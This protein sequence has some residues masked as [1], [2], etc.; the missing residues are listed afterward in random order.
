MGMHLHN[1]RVWQGPRAT[2]A[3]HSRGLAVRFAA[4]TAAIALNAGASLRAD[5]VQPGVD[6]WST[7]RGSSSH[8]FDTKCE[9]DP[10]PVCWSGTPCEGD[11]PVCPSGTP[12]PAGFFG[13]GSDP[14]DDRIDLQGKEFQYFGTG[15]S[16]APA[17]TIMWRKD[18]A[19]LPQ[20]SATAQDEVRI[21]IIALS[22]TS[23]TPITVTYNGG[24]NPELW[25]V[26]VCLSDW[27]QDEG[28]M[29]IKHECSD[30][31]TF[32]SSLLVTP[33]FTFTRQSD[34][35]EKILDIG[36]PQW[37]YSSLDLSAEGSWVHSTRFPIAQANAGD[38]VDA[39]CDGTPEALPVGT[40]NFYPGISPSP[41]DCFTPSPQQQ[42]APTTEAGALAA[43][44]IGPP[45]RG[46]C[47]DED[48]FESC[49]ITTEKECDRK[50]CVWY[51][52]LTCEDIKCNHNPIPTVSQ[53]G[54]VV[55]TLLL[56][57]GAKVYFGR[58][59]QAAIPR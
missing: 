9:G 49:T 17:D 26:D 31:G 45:Q 18:V 29:T 55:L 22:L 46:A 6:M 40:S 12:L 23:S 43:H 42:V 2:P 35:A 56:L 11:P 16:L 44:G 20:C 54:L 30:G 59:L 53:W 47:C 28:S 25:D 1:D 21:E 52:L 51:K 19:T 34:G 38:T 48:T 27:A 10:P 50:K 13:D 3:P 14:F 24:A 4:L 37:E 36:D 57:T 7:P 33:K 58:R 41:C 5:D 32:S 8:E 39:N 15:N